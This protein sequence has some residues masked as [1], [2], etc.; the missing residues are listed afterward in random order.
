MAQWPAW[1]SVLLAI[2]V[3]VSDLYA[4]RVP[5]KLLLLALCLGMVVY[6]GA[7]LAGHSLWGNAATGLLIGL[8][9]LLPFYALGWMG[10]GDVKFFATLGFLLGAPALLPVWLMSAL[11]L[12]IHTLMVLVGRSRSLLAMPGYGLITGFGRLQQITWV[13]RISSRLLSARQGR[14]GMPYAAYLGISAL[15]YVVGST[16]HV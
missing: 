12:G 9:S 6:T 15:A 14:K 4:R 10:A 7:A 16:P 1:I 5:N 13:R 11:L 3:A 2:G 8:G